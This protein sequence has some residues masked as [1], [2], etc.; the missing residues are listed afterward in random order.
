MQ[1][2]AMQF[3]A[4]QCNAMQCN[5]MQCNVVKLSLNI[6]QEES[7]QSQA[8]TKKHNFSAK[9]LPLQFHH[10]RPSQVLNYWYWYSAHSLFQ[11]SNDSKLSQGNIWK[12]G[13]GQPK[14]QQ[15]EPH[16]KVRYSVGQLIGEPVRSL[17][18][19]TTSL[20]CLCLSRVYFMGQ[21]RNKQMSRLNDIWT[22]PI[23]R[24]PKCSVFCT[25]T[26]ILVKIPVIVEQIAMFVLRK[27]GGAF[28]ILQ[29]LDSRKIISDD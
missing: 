11:Y 19:W 26:P 21:S 27:N 29:L 4:M 18:V 8:G 10:D 28:P 6:K 12:K 13:Y 15:T 20:A 2:N 23:L 25:P 3:K 14:H 24:R 22:L 7:K 9:F 16:V 1:C 17:L 5:A